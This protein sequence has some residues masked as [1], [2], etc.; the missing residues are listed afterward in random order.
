MN[1]F[2]Y[3][4]RAKL[5]QFMMGRYG[6][7]QL[8]YA[9][10]AA[11]ILFIILNV[12]F[13]RYAIVSGIFYILSWLMLVLALARVFS[14]NINQRYAENQAFLKVW[15]NV[16]GFFNINFCKV[17]DFP[18][19]KYAKCPHC[20]STLRLPRIRGKHTVRCP[21]CNN[22]FDI[23]I[24]IGTKNKKASKNNA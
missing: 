14:K 1:N 4:F 2:L 8:H 16:K 9:M 17:R 6:I 18:Q 15:N 3:N 13:R 21:Q 23:R 7:D 19:K 5:Q 11:Y 10:L 22:R 12:A 20:K 24:F